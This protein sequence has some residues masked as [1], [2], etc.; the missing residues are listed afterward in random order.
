MCLDFDKFLTAMSSNSELLLVKENK[1]KIEYNLLERPTVDFT[2]SDETGIITLQWHQQEQEESKTRDSLRPLS[3]GELEATEGDNYGFK[4]PASL[5]HK[6]PAIKQ[7]PPAPRK[8]RPV[9]S[10]KRKV[11]SPNI[12]RSL[13]LD[14]S[15][16]VESLFPRPILAD[17]YQKM[18][19]AR[20]DNDDIDT[21]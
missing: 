6:I 20:R 9:L 1:E 11:S 2:D 19:K 5:D 21:H 16:Q 10:T 12:R 15:Q 13:Q 3:L 4:T 14:L 17:L 8:P 7:C 18:K